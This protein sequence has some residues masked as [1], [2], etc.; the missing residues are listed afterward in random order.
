MWFGRAVQGQS[1]TPFQAFTTGLASR[2]GVGNMEAL[3]R[4]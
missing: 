4:Q 3:Q 2:V 1:L